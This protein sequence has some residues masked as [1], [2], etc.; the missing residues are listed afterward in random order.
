M[1]K[2]YG[3]NSNVKADLALL[4][5]RFSTSLKLM[6]CRWR[7]Y[8]QV[9]TTREPH[10]TVF[11]GDVY[12]LTSQYRSLVACHTVYFGTGNVRKKHD[13]TLNKIKMTGSDVSEEP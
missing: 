8:R 9:Y 4:R 10:R 1:I 3:V 13:Y 2:M 5:H 11:R 12:I 6:V 7:V